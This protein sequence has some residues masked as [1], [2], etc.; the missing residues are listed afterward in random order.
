M[1]GFLSNGQSVAVL[2][3][4]LAALPSPDRCLAKRKLT[5]VCIVARNF[6]ARNLQ[7]SGSLLKI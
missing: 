2:S 6:A 1:H 7:F 4:I 5:P 3:K